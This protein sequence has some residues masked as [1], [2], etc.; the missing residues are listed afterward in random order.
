MTGRSLAL[1][2]LALVVRP[3]PVCALTAEVKPLHGSP[4]IFVD[5]KPQTP[6]M[7]FGWATDAGPTRIALAPAWRQYHVTFTAPEDNKGNC[8]VHIRVGSAAGTIWVD[9]AQF[10]EGP[11]RSW[12]ADNR[13]LCGD[14]ESDRPTADAAWTLFVK[15]EVGAKAGWEFD[16]EST[17]AGK[18]SCRITISKPGSAAM[19]VHLY[20]TGLTVKKGKRY[21]FSVWLK[22]DKDREAEIQALHHGPPWRIY[23]GSEDSPTFE[24]F[25]LAAGAGVHMHSFGIPMPW[26]RPGEAPDF[27]GVDRAIEQVLRADPK[28]LLLPR[29][30]C[31]PP[32]WWYELHPDEALQ[33][34]DGT[35]RPVCV[36]SMVWRKEL[37]GHLRRLVEHCEAKYGDHML[38]YHPCAQH[39]GEWFY[40]KTWE[41]RHCGFSPAMRRGFA[42][43]L[44]EKYGT[45]EVLRSAWSRTDASFDRIDVPTVRQRAEASHGLFRDPAR[46]RWVVDFFEYLQVAMVEPLELIAPVIKAATQRRK[47]V[48][49]FYGYLFEI[50]GLPLGPQTSGH[51]KLARLLGHPDV[52]IV[53]SPISYLDRG[54]GGIGAFMVPVD[55]V[56][57]AGKLWLNEDD[58]RTYLTPKNAGYGRVETPQQTAWVHQRDFGRLLPRRLACWYMDLG[59]TGWLGGQDIWDNVAALRAIYDRHL[60]E[61]ATW[62][63][64][65]AVIVDEESPA[66]LACNRTIMSPL[67]SG[68]RQ[69]LY[70]M[71]A[72]FGIYL[73]GDFVNGR[74]PPAKV[75]LF[76]GCFHMTPNVREAIARQLPGRTA[77]WFYGSGYLSDRASTDQMSDLIGM[78]LR[79]VTDPTV[80]MAKVT[81]ATKPLTQGLS[82]VSFG[83]NQKLRPIW[84]VEPAP[85][86]ETIARFGDQSIAVAAV[87]K[88][89]DRSVYI[90]TVTAPAGL[91]RNTL[92]TGGVHVWIDTDD[93]LLTDG[94]FLCIEASAAGKKVVH[95]P[96]TRRILDLPSRKEVAQ[97]AERIEVTLAR[98]ETRLYW[99][100]DARSSNE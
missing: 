6:L 35:R 19:H 9:D 67:L 69:Q 91:L 2:A 5:G 93:V 88:D 3:T 65:V 89:G 20:Q 13:L 74:V 85:E 70:R 76:L 28:A 45:V 77:V 80:A 22:A 75:I 63:P 27:S 82:G 72:P 92:R 51:L 97:R 66:Y 18:Q 79:E 1:V 95:L 46:E 68:I 11:F 87:K 61:P 8:G 73:L 21:T 25:R 78:R 38:G 30:G 60:T 64:E 48:V 84:A 49:F 58:T 24:E 41:A 94:S 31:D 34:D 96:S 50:S 47:L 23:S 15:E 37:P 12:C 16:T 10:H 62:S 83:S 36:A 33:F 81:E 42:A 55:S 14:W 86:L 29:F 90:G 44:K 7:F 71:G 52:D 54:L 32:G 53:C 26:P 40:P 57:A 56:R 100:E 4:T 59:G 17:H 98:G 39:T 99:L 43:W